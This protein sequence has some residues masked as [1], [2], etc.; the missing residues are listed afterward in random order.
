MRQ[1]QREQIATHWDGWL[2]RETRRRNWRD[3]PFILRWLHKRVCGEPLD[4]PGA[5]G[6][7]RVFLKRLGS[8]RLRSGLSIG[9][10]EGRREIELVAGGHVEEMTIYELSPV[11]IE[12]GRKLAQESGVGNRVH[13]LCEDGMARLDRGY[14]LVFWHAALHHMFDTPTAIERTWE[15]LNPGGYFWA[16]EYTGPSKALYTQE[17]LSWA[18]TIRRMFPAGYTERRPPRWPRAVH[19]PV[20]PPRPDRLDPSEAADSGRITPTIQRVMPHA[21]VWPLGGVGYL[22]AFN[23]MSPRFDPQS[24]ED[25]EWIRAMMVIDDRLSEGGLNLRH[26]ILAQK[27]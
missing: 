14:D 22:I 4:G 24:T 6:L 19:I 26:A 16:L 27:P 17:M 5:T 2:K 8:E 12:S 11:W 9:G 13:F 18:T 21:D 1:G 7:N 10:G 20:P 23:P 15:V 25:E 3:F